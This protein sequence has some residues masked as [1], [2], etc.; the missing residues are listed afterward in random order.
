MEKKEGG[1]APPSPASPTHT[2]LRLLPCGHLG[3]ETAAPEASGL[4]PHT[5]LHGAQAGWN[6]GRD[7]VGR[8]VCEC[9]CECV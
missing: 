5:V 7:T 6:V 3:P 1:R 2:Q 4:L 9:V 8:H